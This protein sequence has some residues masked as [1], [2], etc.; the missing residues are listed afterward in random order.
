M[1]FNEAE[2]HRHCNH[3]LNQRRIKNKIVILC[4][5]GI[6]QDNGRPSPQ[7]YSRMEQMPDANFY[8]G[9]V[10]KC[11]KQSLPEFVICGDK[12]NVL[13]TYYT[14]LQ[15][16]REGKDMGYLKPENLFAIVDLDLQKQ[17]ID[18]YDFLDTDEI[19]LD[20]YDEIRVNVQT[21][22]QHHIWVTGLIYKE[23]YFMIPELQAVFDNYENLPKYDERPLQ[24]DDVYLS[25]CNDIEDDVSIQN[26]LPIVRDRIRY[27]TGLDC[28]DTA[29]LK[30]SWQQQFKNSQ[31][32]SSEKE[33]LVFALLTIKQVKDYWRKIQPPS[34]WTGS[35]E[36]L[37]DQLSL[38]IADFYSR[39]YEDAKYHISFLLHNLYARLNESTPS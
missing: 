34:D 35:I 21:A 22:S 20:L 3:I 9:C 5:G 38:Q 24:L 31:L 27:C 18:D 37:R 23:A 19:F 26:S 28:A 14:L 4:E 30:D 16:H 36:I 6:P 10:P 11:W 17:Q 39:N 2:L 32:P 7:S 15:W 25:M 12:R 13:D 1:S 8:K 33:K 29:K